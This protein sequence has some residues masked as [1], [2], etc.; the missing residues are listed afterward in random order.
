MIN[1]WTGMPMTEKCEKNTYKRRSFE[2]LAPLIK[3]VREITK[4]ILGM[5]GFAEVDILSHWTDIIGEDL[6]RGIRPEKLVF[7]KNK[8][9]DGTLYVKSA[10]GAFAMLFE[11]Q[12]GQVVER[13]NGFFGYPAVTQ[14]KIRQG[15]LRLDKNDRVEKTQLSKDQEKQL[16]KKVAG[17]SDD[18]LKQSTYQ[19]GKAILLKK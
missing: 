10:G 4:P 5:R 15:S 8:R 13:I 12:K 1:L 11:F 14:V 6:A 18:D 7:E 2:G 3:E 16:R 17:I 19:V 9:T